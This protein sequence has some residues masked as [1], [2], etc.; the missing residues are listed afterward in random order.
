MTRFGKNKK[1]N[2]G[3]GWCCHCIALIP[4]KKNRENGSDLAS[5]I[6]TIH[7]F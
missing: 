1:I 5:Y 4:Y 6:V 3:L 2:R 7:W